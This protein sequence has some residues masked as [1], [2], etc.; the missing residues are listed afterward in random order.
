M[1]EPNP[2]ELLEEVR[3]GYTGDAFEDLH[4]ECAKGNPPSVYLRA[5]AKRAKAMMPFVKDDP[6]THYA[7]RIMEQTLEAWADE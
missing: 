3:K 2:N 4:A 1:A 7:Y 6:A 5:L